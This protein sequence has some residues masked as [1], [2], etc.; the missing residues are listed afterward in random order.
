MRICPGLASSQ[1][2]EATLERSLWQ[3]SRTALRSRL[4]LPP[5]RPASADAVLDCPDAPLASDNDNPAAA[6]S[7]GTAF[8]RRL[9]FWGCSPGPKRVLEAVRKV[10]KKN[11]EGGCEAASRNG[12]LFAL[13]VWLAGIHCQERPPGASRIFVPR[14]AR[15][16][17]I[18][19]GTA[20]NRPSTWV[21]CN[22]QPRLSRARSFHRQSTTMRSRR[23]S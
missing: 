6:P 22:G 20:T 21:T 23:C 16:Q 11:P 9:R 12:F 1:R 17:Q 19:P 3:R 4:S 8:L 5:E 14:L 18:R 10:A 15:F 13:L 2:R 7:A